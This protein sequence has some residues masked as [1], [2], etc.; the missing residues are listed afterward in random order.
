MLEDMLDARQAAVL[1][2]KPDVKLGGKCCPLLQAGGAGT[3]E[4]LIA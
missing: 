2:N 4:V 3:A 1:G